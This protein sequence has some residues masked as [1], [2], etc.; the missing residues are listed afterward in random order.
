[1]ET[2][3]KLLCVTGPAKTGYVGTKYTLLL[4]ELYFVIGIEY[5]HC[6]NCEQTVKIS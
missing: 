2:C 1:M 3:L 5:F 4:N 6:D